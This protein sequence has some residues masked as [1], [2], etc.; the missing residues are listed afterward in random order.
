MPTPRPIDPLDDP[1]YRFVAAVNAYLAVTANVDPPAKISGSQNPLE[2][3]Q[4]NW[5][6]FKRHIQRSREALLGM[7]DERREHL[8]TIV[9]IGV[10]IKALT[11]DPCI[12]N[13]VD[14]VVVRATDE[15]AE[16]GNIIPHMANATSVPTVMSL[17]GELF[18][19][20][21]RALARRREITKMLDDLTAYF[22]LRPPPRQ[23]A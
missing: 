10:E 12:V 14:G 15:R 3:I 9:S 23:S 4:R 8:E 7:Q 2:H 20:G 11:D 19:F 1:I 18:G 22:L 16:L 21:T 13:P 17:I 6:E 5:D